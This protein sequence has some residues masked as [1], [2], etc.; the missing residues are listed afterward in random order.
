MEEEELKISKNL[1][2]TLT[3]DTRT[4]I[5]K[6]LEKRPMTASE[7]SRKLGKHVTTVSEHLNLLKNSDL[8][9]RVERPGRKWIYYKLTKPAEKIL[10]PTSYKWSFIFLTIFLSSI[11]GWYFLSV[12]AY[13][14]SALYSS[15]RAIENFQLLL[16]TDNLQKAELHIQHAEQRL[17]ETK[18]VADTGQTELIAG[19]VQDYENEINQA[20]NEIQIAKQK[21][22]NVI[23]ILEIL[24][25]STAKHSAALQ[26]IAIKEP[27]MSKEIQP[28][29][30]ISEES[31]KMAV[32]NLENITEAKHQE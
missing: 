1:L 16:T 4:D 23:P 10:R 15:K 2:K 9:E 18:Q 6:T 19:V 3:V 7:L 17:Q 11:S 28:A 27:E 25:E 22:T 8:V 13:P 12:N 26:N 5:L 24:S 21:K 30:N 31:R 14:G 32:E 29:L 20:Q